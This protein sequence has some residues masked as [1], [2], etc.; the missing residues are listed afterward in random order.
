MDFNTEE[1]PAI[2]AR[3]FV[4]EVD[5]LPKIPQDFHAQMNS[6][7][8][9]DR[10]EALDATLDVVKASI[11]IKDEGIGEL[12]RALAKR[13]TDANVMC[14]IAAAN[15][16]GGIAK[17][18]GQPFSKYKSIVMPPMIERFKERKANVVEAISNGLDEVFATVSPDLFNHPIIC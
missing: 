9:K 2:D 18:V 7:K 6:S 17:G 3:E 11:K 12:L 4:E 8:W 10:K 16:I 1:E 14:V 15:I 13:M 5:I